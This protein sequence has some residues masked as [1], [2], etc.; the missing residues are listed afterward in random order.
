MKTILDTGPLVA[1]LNR[2]DQYHAWTLQ[3]LERLPLPL[4]TCEPVLAEA[5]Y[6]TGRGLEILHMLADGQLR[7]GLQLEDQAEAVARLLSRYGGT[8]DL[9]DACIVR[10]SELT[11]K[12]QVFTTDRRDFRVY[13]RSGREV[14]PLLAPD[15]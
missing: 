15:D 10:M 3:S 6:L 14:I 13:R 2:A 11:R 1:L 8:M 7:I 5:S 9:A 4:W 12:C